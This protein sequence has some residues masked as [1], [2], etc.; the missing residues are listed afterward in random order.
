MERTHQLKAA[1]GHQFE[2]PLVQF[3]DGK[4][5]DTDAEYFDSR[6]DFGFRGRKSIETVLYFHHGQDP[7]IGLTE[8]GAGVL[9]MRED[10]VWLKGQLDASQP[11]ADDLA[12]LAGAG[13]LGLSSGSLSHLVKR[14]KTG[15]AHRIDKWPLGLDASLT[16]TPADCRT[17]ARAYKSDFTIALERIEAEH[18]RARAHMRT[19]A[20]RLVA[21]AAVKF[22]ARSYVG[23]AWKREV[24]RKREQYLARIAGMRRAG[25]FGDGVPSLD[26]LKARIEQARVWRTG[27]QALMTELEARRRAFVDECRGRII[28][29]RRAA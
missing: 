14:T 18:A 26:A 23:T 13:A 16:P 27:G 11:F 19:K 4:T 12:D 8:I 21:E 5:W 24:L 10:S 6:T 7:T 25:K 2:G 15:R 20:Y 22:D 28:A 1:G 3:S 29:A 9:T 17:F